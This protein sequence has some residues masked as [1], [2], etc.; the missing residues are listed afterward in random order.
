[1]A[2][3]PPPEFHLEVMQ[4]LI[5]RGAAGF[6]VEGESSSAFAQ[7]AQA[8]LKRV[9][10]NKKELPLVIVGHS[11]LFKQWKAPGCFWGDSPAAWPMN[12][13]PYMGKVEWAGSEV[14][15]RETYSIQE[16]DVVMIRHAHS[17]AQEARKKR[18]RTEP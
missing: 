4:E 12:F 10:E 17:E 14:R 16:A 11:L 1:M 8:A 9:L 13:K 6:S 18:K 3:Y 7:R 2:A 5:E 15:L